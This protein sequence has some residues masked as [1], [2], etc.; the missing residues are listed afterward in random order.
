MKNYF[1]ILLF[2]ILCS[3]CQKNN[4]IIDMELNYDIIPVPKEI[5]IIQKNKGLSFDKNISV[6]SNQPEIEKLLKVFKKD[7]KNVS[8]LNIDF[9]ITSKED[10]NMVFD[11]QENYQDEQY[12]IHVNEKIH[13]R[14]SLSKC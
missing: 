4:E 9:S 8:S 13:K 6:F 1:K 14:W 3:S 7:I 10:A 2:F 5:E 11:I 12:S